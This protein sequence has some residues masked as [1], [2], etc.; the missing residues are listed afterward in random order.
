MPLQ[1]RDET[2]GTVLLTIGD[3]GLVCF[4][5]GTPVSPLTVSS[6]AV[7]DNNGLISNQRVPSSA[8]VGARGSVNVGPGQLAMVETLPGRRA[9]AQIDADFP[10]VRLEYS[11]GGNG[12][13]AG[14]KTP[15]PSWTDTS[16]RIIALTNGGF[17]IRSGDVDHSEGRCTSPNSST[18]DYRWM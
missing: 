8:L 17:S 10:A 16:H 14:C 9:T 12:I 11:P 13:P 4:G 6:I 18:V 3:D 1:I 5:A 2:A 15:V 7:V